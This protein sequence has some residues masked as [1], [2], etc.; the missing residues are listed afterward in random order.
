MLEAFILSNPAATE[1]L[2]IRD[3]VRERAAD[4]RVEVSGGGAGT[5]LA[6][7][8]FK[9]CEDDE[10]ALK[11]P[12]PCADWTRTLE[13]EFVSLAKDAALQRITP[14]KATRLKQLRNWRRVLT[15]KRTPVEIAWEHKKRRATKNLLTA[16]Q[17]YAKLHDPAN[18]PWA[19]AKENLH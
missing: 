10:L 15:N 19:L 17:Q 4:M 9:V 13:K 14:D 11:V 18:S 3:G 6:E 1:A 7:F 2:L 5:S 16:L 12:I 8:V